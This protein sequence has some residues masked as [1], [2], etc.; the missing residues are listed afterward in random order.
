MAKKLTDTM[1]ALSLI[2]NH[3]GD[4]VP[5]VKVKM[6]ADKAKKLPKEL[7]QVLPKELTILS[8][9][10]CFPRCIPLASPAASQ[11]ANH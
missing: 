10:R 9:P 11:G 2:L 8:F 1:G 5:L 4:I 6:M 7:H 3:P